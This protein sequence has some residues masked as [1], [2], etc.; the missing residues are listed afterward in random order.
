MATLEVQQGGCNNA[1]RLRRPDDVMDRCSSAG[2]KHPGTTAHA[3]RQAWWAGKLAAGDRRLLAEALKQ[4]RIASAK[5]GKA[6]QNEQS[7]KF[8]LPPTVPSPLLVRTSAAAPCHCRCARAQQ[9][10]ARAPRHAPLWCASRLDTRPAPGLRATQVY[11]RAVC[12]CPRLRSSRARC[13]TRVRARAAQAAPHAAWAV[14]A[15]HTPCT[16]GKH[17]TRAAARCFTPG[18]PRERRGPRRARRGAHEQPPPPGERGP[19]PSPGLH[20]P[21]RVF[22]SARARPGAASALACANLRPPPCPRPRVTVVR[23]VPEAGR[24]APPLRRPRCTT[25][26][27]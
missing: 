16:A 17:D 14:P 8:G 3:G 18:A 11:A 13:A 5:F 10:R 2:A 7:A 15:S 22:R 19:R 6:K 20:I 24:E 21:A 23:G 9:A 1:A 12:G 4:R 26:V 27:C 25:R